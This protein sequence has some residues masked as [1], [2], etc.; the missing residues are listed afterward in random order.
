MPA[1]HNEHHRST[2]HHVDNRHPEELR[3]GASGGDSLLRLRDVL[4]ERGAVERARPQPRDDAA[5]D[6]AAVASTSRI[7]G[8]PPCE[9]QSPRWTGLGG[10][11]AGHDLDV[12]KL[13]DD[14]HRN[15]ATFTL[16]PSALARAARKNVRPSVWPM[17]AT[18][19]RRPGANCPNDDVGIADMLS[20]RR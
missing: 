1:C 13:Q 10:A 19:S 4:V 20:A 6:R 15:A 14:F 7:V 17:R 12:E 3:A 11:V 2:Q 18:R 5:G 8:R 16:P 9:A